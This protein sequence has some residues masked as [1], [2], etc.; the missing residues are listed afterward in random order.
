MSFFHSQHR[1]TFNP[2]HTPVTKSYDMLF[3]LCCLSFDLLVQDM[4][5]SLTGT[6]KRH[7]MAYPKS[8]VVWGYNHFGMLPKDLGNF[9]ACAGHVHKPDRHKQAPPYGRP[10][11]R[12]CAG[13]QPLWY[14]GSSSMVA[15]AVVGHHA[16][17]SCRSPWLQA[18]SHWSLPGRW[19]CCHADH[20]VSRTL[21]T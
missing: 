2:T 3:C 5:T 12:G 10:R 15:A 11:D 17:S 7:H 20:D 4:F 6:S 13:V 1:T 18:Q 14:A 9:S 16:K 8:G 21:F 19:Y